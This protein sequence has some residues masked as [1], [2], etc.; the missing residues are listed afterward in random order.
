MRKELSRH[1]TEKGPEALQTSIHLIF[2]LPQAMTSSGEKV[3]APLTPHTPSYPGHGCLCHQNK[4]F[5]GR[6]L[7][8]I[9]EPQLVQQ[10]LHFSCHSI[11]LQQAVE[12]PTQQSQREEPKIS[13]GPGERDRDSASHWSDKT[14]VRDLYGPGPRLAS[15]D[16]P[17]PHQIQYPLTDQRTGSAVMDSTPAFKAQ[18]ET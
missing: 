18:P 3:T 9:R 4:V 16:P 2:I 17:C 5:L 8:S 10:N 11:V 7:N 1:Y 12:G 14:Q 6:Q 13:G 15:K